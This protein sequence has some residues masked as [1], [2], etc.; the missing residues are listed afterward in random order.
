ML[1]RPSSA[2]TRAS[3]TR[4]DVDFQAWNSH[5]STA[6]GYLVDS[7]SIPV[8]TVSISALSQCPMTHTLPP[9][10][11]RISAQLF[12][13]SKSYFGPR[14]NCVIARWHYTTILHTPAT[15]HTPARVVGV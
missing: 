8:S 6:Q 13:L 2:L 10:G 7:Q 1:V 3:L 5:L 12:A 15:A 9:Q 4:S 14:G 11:Q